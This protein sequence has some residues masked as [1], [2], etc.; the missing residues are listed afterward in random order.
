MRGTNSFWRLLNFVVCSRSDGELCHLCRRFLADR[1]VEGTC[2]FCAY[3]VSDLTGLI[4]RFVCVV[5]FVQQASEVRPVGM[6]L[7]I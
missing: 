4:L 6:G 5:V 1:F 2:P 3:E 7:L